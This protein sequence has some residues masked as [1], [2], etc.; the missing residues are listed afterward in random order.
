ME[1]AELLLS[2]IITTDITSVNVPLVN[3][4]LVEC[5]LKDN[6]ECLAALLKLVPAGLDVNIKYAGN[7]KK[8]ALAIATDM[9]HVSVIRQLLAQPGIEID[10]SHLNPIL[11]LA[12]YENDIECVRLLL[13]IPNLNVNITSSIDSGLTSLMI[14]CDKNHIEIVKLFLALAD[15]N[16]NARSRRGNVAVMFAMNKGYDECARLLLES[17]K[18][19]TNVVNQDGEAIITLCAGK[20]SEETIKVLLSKPGLQ[21]N[22]QNQNGSTALIIASKRLPSLADLFLAID[23]I[24]T[25][26][27]NKSG[28]FFD[29]E[30]KTIS[31]ASKLA[32]KVFNSEPFTTQLFDV[33]LTDG[34]LCIAVSES[35]GLYI[36]DI[37]TNSL[38]Y[39]QGLLKNGDEIIELN[40]K[41]V[42]TEK[43]LLE[44]MKNVSNMPSVNLKIKRA[45][46]DSENLPSVS[47]PVSK[48]DA[49]PYSFPFDL[50]FTP[51]ETSISPFTFTP[52]A[53]QPLSSNSDAPSASTVSSSPL[54]T[55]P[56]QPSVP[57][58]APLGGLVSFNSATSAQP[59]V[60]VFLTAPN[61]GH[62]SASMLINT[63]R[64]LSF[65]SANSL[66]FVPKFITTRENVDT[67]RTV[68]DSSNS[69]N[70][71]TRAR[72]KT[73]YRAAGGPATDTSIP[74]PN[75]FDVV[76]L[77]D[78]T[79]IDRGFLVTEV[80]RLNCMLFHSMKNRN[81][82]EVKKLMSQGADMDNE[83]E[84]INLN[85]GNDKSTVW[86]TAITN[87]DY[88]LLEILLP[89]APSYKLDRRINVNGLTV[90]ML[91]ARLGSLRC[92]R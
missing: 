31:S 26:Q 79:L 81:L 62:P 13:N 86:N 57:V 38:A 21:V 51:P 82:E 34:R 92:L 87:C 70:N 67:Q 5:A 66:S 68:K 15:T 39:K 35:N 58:N 9:G 50:K 25:K 55:V 24:D 73:K 2:L 61:S 72:G 84:W 33:P 37:D 14:A 44:S 40:G 18:I 23:G 36:E 64:E 42:M 6:T 32:F 56:A 75:F 28:E 30:S 77:L 8:T 85:Q 54:F 11:L 46:S 43:E 60:N 29:T 41:V 74:P 91:F 48:V 71:R 19:D 17:D 20:S 47:L 16:I 12:V 89:Y 3:P 65:N 52:P 78:D 69:K 90:L 63:P 88:E 59:Q 49:V 76:T 22:I 83:R 10:S 27:V 7:N 1:C 80:S 4:L 53:S 45:N